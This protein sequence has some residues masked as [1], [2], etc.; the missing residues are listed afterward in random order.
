MIVLFNFIQ[1][2]LL[3]RKLATGIMSPTSIS[4]GMNAKRLA[5]SVGVQTPAEKA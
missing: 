4:G 5:N 3:Y 1:Q 2:K